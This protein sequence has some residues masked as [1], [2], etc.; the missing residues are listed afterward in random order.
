MITIVIPSTSILNI[1]MLSGKSMPLLFITASPTTC[2]RVR[3]DLNL[4]FK[5][6]GLYFD[7]TSPDE[8]MKRITMLPEKMPDDVKTLLTSF[9]T[10]LISELDNKTANEMLVKS[11]PKTSAI[12]FQQSLQKEKKEVQ[13][14]SGFAA[15][16]R[17]EKYCQFPATG[18]NTVS[19]TQED[20]FCLEDESFLNDVI[21]DFYF[22]WIQETIIPSDLK[23]KTHIFTTYFY[24]RLTTR[25]PRSNNKLH[26]IEDDVNL[27]NAEKRLVYFLINF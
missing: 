16:N 8:T 12:S 17:I 10:N 18:S 14:D 20:Y 19:V 13:K 1:E 24:K 9:Y 15:I 11:T 7:L 27:S 3:Q 5:N 2:T 25:P 6:S 23:D 4:N 26:P 22:K 21:I